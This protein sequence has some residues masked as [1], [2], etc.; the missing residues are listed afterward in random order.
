MYIP[1]ME[2]QAFLTHLIENKPRLSTKELLSVNKVVEE[3]MYKNNRL[4]LH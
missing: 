2:K 3:G 1:D 4:G